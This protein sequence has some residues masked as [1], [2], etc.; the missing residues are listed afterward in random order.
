KEQVF[1]EKLASLLK[2][3]VAS[4]RFKD[5]HDL[6]YLGH[7]PDFDRQRLEEYLGK[8][9]YGSSATW[10]PM[11]DGSGIGEALVAILNDGIYR[12]GFASSKDKWLDVDDDEAIG[13]L[14]GYFS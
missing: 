11:T 3:G 6:Y 5:I 10:L 8:W 7:R 2:W 14:I 12:R 4:T 9:V 1:G 13:W